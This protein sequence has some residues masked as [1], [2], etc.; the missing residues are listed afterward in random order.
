MKFHVA[1]DRKEVEYESEKHRDTGLYVQGLVVVA[2]VICYYCGHWEWMIVKSR[3]FA[4]CA[5]M[6]A[7]TRPLK[8]WRKKKDTPYD[9]PRSFAE[10]LLFFIGRRRVSEAVT[11]H[12]VRWYFALAGLVS[13]DV[14]GVERI[15]FVDSNGTGEKLARL[16]R[17]RRRGRP[18]VGIVR[19]ASGG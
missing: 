5:I 13:S 2:V 19:I 18:C 16:A 9:G 11:R 12:D 8:T 3:Y 1:C 7:Q 15:V 6:F 17:L 4:R 14:V 10:R